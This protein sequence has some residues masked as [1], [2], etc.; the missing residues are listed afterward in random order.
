M[1]GNISVIDIS[2]DDEN[3]AQSTSIK[4]LLFNMMGALNS[5]GESTKALQGSNKS[6]NASTFY[7]DASPR[8]VGVDI[9]H[10]ESEEDER[11]VLVEELAALKQRLAILRNQ[12]PLVNCLS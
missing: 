6:T 9:I 11:A 10:K 5:S 1:N 12:T 7:S 4:F 3:I 2:S 8:K